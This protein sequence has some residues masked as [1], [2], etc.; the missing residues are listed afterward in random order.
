MRKDISRSLLNYTREE[1]L[2]MNHS[3]MARRYNCDRRTIKHYIEQSEGEILEKKPRKSKDTLLEGYYETIINKVDTYGASA[4]AVYKFIVK[5]GYQGK[6]STVSNYVRKHKDMEQKKATIRFETSPGLQAQVDWKEDLTLI[7]RQGEAFKVNIF[8]M[9]LGYSRLKYV[10][11]TSDRTRGTLFHS[12]IGAFGYFGGIPAE[13]LFDNMKTVVDHSQSTFRQTVINENFRYFALDSGFKTITCR[14]Y[15]PQ[16]K[17]KVESLAKLMDRLVVYNNEFD[18]FEDLEEIV[19]TF[20]D[21]IN[22]EVSQATDEKPFERFEKEKEYLKPLPALDML[23]S[24]ISL[25]RTYKVSKESMIKYKGKKYS[26]PI[27]Y[28]SQQL[29]VN[30]TSDGNLCIYYNGDFV[31]CHPMTDKKLNYKYGHMHEILKSDACKHLSDDDI[32]D[33]IHDNMVNM[34]LFL[35]D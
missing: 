21:E 35:G 20:N 2:L 10:C 6:Y 3:E 14:P 30:E 25:D 31:V 26:V 32:S 29:S 22:A 33:F 5:K 34:D 23:L 1:L 18:T 7:N 16:T 13:I 4:M 11:L 8:L 9:V 17:G 27:K 15:R 28:I 12:M 19:R 24:Y